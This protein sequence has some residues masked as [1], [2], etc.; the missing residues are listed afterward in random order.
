MLFKVVMLYVGT[1][2]GAGFA[3]GQE[4]LQFFIKYGQQGLWGVMLATVLF[5]YYGAAIMYLATK[6][7][8]RSYKEVLPYILGPGA[9]FIDALSLVM[10]VCG[11]GVMFAGSGAILHQYLGI[12]LSVGIILALMIVL[13][14]LCGG[15]TR[16]LSANLLLVPIKLLAIIIVALLAVLN[17]ATGE[18]LAGT[19]SNDLV[20]SHWLWASMLFCSYNIV[21]PMAVLSSL[22]RMVT[23]RLG[24]VA[25]ITGG[26]L[27][28]LATLLVTL[29][30]LA[31]YP[32][33]NN[34]A[35]PLLY[36][37]TVVAPVLKTF[38]ALL[39]W[40]A[41]ITTAIADAHGFSSRMAP[42]G[43]RKYKLVALSVCVLVLPLAKIDF[44][45]L[46][47]K[48]YPLFGYGGLILMISLGIMP[49]IK[50]LR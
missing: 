15:V 9:K 14:V 23:P 5:S 47:Q 33:V 25:G 2:I 6:F 26:V 41:I 34:Y 27:L 16:V 30:G 17:P 40:L 4:I 8:T 24:I 13:A 22:G 32:T 12:P 31:F 19:P 10:L 36:I 35:I 28:G 49:F 29:A 7:N 48:L 46:V 44:A 18:P 50:A 38:I 20:A 43:G 3:S 21:A 42:E 37:A 1:V 39:I 11:V 45:N